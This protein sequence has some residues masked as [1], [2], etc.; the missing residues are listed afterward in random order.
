M[1]SQAGVARYGLPIGTPISQTNAPG[2]NNA[3]TQKSYNTF[4][5][6]STPADLN[7]A[8]G[9]MSNADLAR[10]GQTLF[11]FKSKNARD[12]AARIAL[13]KEF[14]ARGI[15]PHQ[16]GYKGG[17]VVLNPNPKLDPTVQ[18]ANKLKQKAATAAKQKASA[19][20]KA[21]ATA[22]RAVTKQAQADRQAA[23]DKTT[24][25][26]QD[27][28]QALAKGIVEGTISTSRAHKQMRTLKRHSNWQNLAAPTRPTGG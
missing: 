18:A 12:E 20:Q 11:S 24:K 5:S 7:R 16:H 8:A 13:V 15:D 2:K 17:P 19:Q 4:M 3:A 1:A 6:A 27:A 9:W 25:A 23:R 22:A 28:K 10:A 26:L 14:A 21:A